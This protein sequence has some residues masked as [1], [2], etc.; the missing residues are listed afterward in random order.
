MLPNPAAP[1]SCS[2]P[3]PTP[4]IDVEKITAEL[5]QADGIYYAGQQLTEWLGF[6]ERIELAHLESLY[7]RQKPDAQTRY[8][9][10][11][12]RRLAESLVVR[13]H[14]EDGKAGAVVSHL[15][16]TYPEGEGS[17]VLAQRA[18][19]WGSAKRHVD[20]YRLGHALL[21][22][23][24]SS[25][26]LRSS[27]AYIHETMA[28]LTE[29]AGE[30]GVGGVIAQKTILKLVFEKDILLTRA[31]L[32]RLRTEAQEAGVDVEQGQANTDHTSSDYLLRTLCSRMVFNQ[33]P[34]AAAFARHAVK[35]LPE[36]RALLGARDEEW[37][38]AA[39]RRVSDA[40]ATVA[41]RSAS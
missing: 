19:I 6:E 25:H 40:L 3:P 21:R 4:L 18:F 29:H 2:D 34:D 33:G 9:D 12:A 13:W 26:G 17:E 32:E 1:S 14:V 35:D 30:D 22:D 20:V 16:D 37:T 5:R 10:L 28:V 23:T 11:R 31:T 24:I 38:M 27:N 36:I 15:Y 7:A 41:D 39:I 8:D